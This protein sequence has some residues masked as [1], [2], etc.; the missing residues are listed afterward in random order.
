MIPLIKFNK[1]YYNPIINGNK[2]QTLRNHNKRLKE[3]EIA[4]AIFPGTELEVKIRITKT[5]YKQFKYLTEEDA[6]REGYMSLK[7]L[8]TELHA[9]YPRLDPHDRLY[10]Y[11]FEV[12]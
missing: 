5:G 10:Y 4:K 12:V 8:K 1:K 9:I 11:Q 3:D 7:E 2:T 6:E